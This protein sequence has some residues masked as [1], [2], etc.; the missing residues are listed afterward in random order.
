[1]RNENWEVQTASA[2]P[3]TLLGALN[4]RRESVTVEINRLAGAR[5]GWTAG[6]EI[7]HRDYRSIFPGTVLTGPLLSQGNQV[8]QTALLSYELWRW[9]EHRLKVSG[10]VSSQ[11]ARIWSQPG[12]AFEKLQALLETHW[13]PR[14]GG[15]DYETLWRIRGG[16]T[17]GQVPFDEL[18]MLGVERDNDLWLRGHLG[19]RHGHKGSAPLGSNYFLSN[20][21][22]DKNVYSN[23]LIT[24]KLGPLLDTGKIIQPSSLLGSHKW[25]FDAGAQAKLRVLGVGVVLSYGKDL[26]SGN[27]AFFATVAH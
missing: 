7:S 19:D 24:I 10:R 13:F 11:A 4:L 2:G 22:T 9:P 27:N 26:R 12:Q 15:D 3:S 20:W 5:L 14:S 8:K 21:E 25:L 23:G 1:L 17:F 6:V 18:F 16:K